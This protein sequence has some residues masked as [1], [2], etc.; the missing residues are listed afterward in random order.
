M[1][2]CRWEVKFYEKPN[3]RRPTEDFLDTLSHEEVARMD[4][5]IGRLEEYG[6]ELSWPYVEHLR[7]KIYELRARCR[8]VRLRI[9]YFRDGDTFLLCN[10][11]RKKT[12]RVPDS[13]IDKA[14]AFRED[15]FARKKENLK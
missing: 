11:I 3:G 12:G 14:I 9:L 10:G 4:R 13:E 2:Q 1:T 6:P 5:Q 8:K 7:D 15:H